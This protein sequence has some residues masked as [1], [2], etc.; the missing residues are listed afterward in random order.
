MKTTLIFPTILA[1]ALPLALLAQATNEP[2]AAPAAG[3][4]R[5]AIINKLER[6]RLDTVSY[7]GLPL[8]EVVLHLRDQAKKLDPEKKGINFLINQNLD[9][10][11][12]ITTP[13]PMPMLGPDGNPLPAA[14][15]EQ[16]DV[17]AIGVRI[18]PPLNDVRLVDV[19]DAVVKVADHPIKYSIEDYGVVFSPRGPEPAKTMDLANATPAASEGRQVISNKLERIRLDN[20]KYDGLPLGE[21]VLM[22]RD[23]AKKR[24]PDNKGINFLLNQNLDPGEVTPAPTVVLGPNGEPMPAPPTEQVDLSAISIRI[25]PPLNAVRLVDVLDAVAK[26]ADR[27]IKYSIEDYGVV[28]SPRGSGPAQIA[29]N[30]FAFPGGTPDQFLDAVQQQYRVDWLSMADIPKEMADVHIP[31]LRISQESLATLT[32][33]RGANQWLSALVSLYNLVGQKKPE[34]GTL[35]VQGDLAKPSVVMFVPDKAVADTQLKIK[36]KAFS[37]SGISDAERARLQ[38]DIDRAKKEAMQYASRLRGSPGPRSLDGMVAMHNDTS[39]LVATGS[40]SF[41]DMVESIVNACQAK[42][43]ARNPG[44]PTTLPN[45]P[46]K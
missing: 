21:V 19:L 46:E 11:E 30:G 44:A 1:L 20:V 6:I 5:Q 38:E 13:A 7:D 8:G 43:R 24:D 23:E 41:V 29:E 26:V 27:P 9:S 4:G 40:E 33:L 37:I 2:P 36:V 14:S 42:E 10:G 31:R 25:S 3:S 28:F 34:L 35:L 12:A 32:H 16:V 15:P 17:S 39:L 18:K 22:L 45:Q